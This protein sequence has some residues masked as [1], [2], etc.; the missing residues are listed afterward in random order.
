MSCRSNSKDCDHRVAVA[1]LAV[2]LEPGQR[3]QGLT[4]RVLGHDGGIGQRSV[5]RRQGAIQDNVLIWRIEEY[6]TGASHR[7]G[8][9]L[10]PA[11]NVATDDVRSILQL[12][13]VQVLAQDSKTARLPVH[14]R[15]LG[16]AA[17]QGLDADRAGAG[18][19]IE[20]V[21]AFDP[22]TD[23]VEHRRLDHALRGPDAFGRLQ[24]PAPRVA[25]TDPQS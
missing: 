4:P 14:E 19:Q 15:D 24:A 18:E 9:A 5:Q 17:R 10:E 23:D 25:T 22:R 8:R 21:G 20:D 3:W 2:E 1:A 7:V 6:E 12:E 16:G 11:D 13:G